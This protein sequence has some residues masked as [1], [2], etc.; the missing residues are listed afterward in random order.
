MSELCL[1][2][3]STSLDFHPDLLT[4]ISC[5]FVLFLLKVELMNYPRQ[6]DRYTELGNEES[7][8]KKNTLQDCALE[9]QVRTRQGAVPWHGVF[10]A[11]LGTAHLNSRKEAVIVLC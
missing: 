8:L 9:P 5:L 10:W 11:M 7:K 6:A 2:L 1:S 3:N 4:K